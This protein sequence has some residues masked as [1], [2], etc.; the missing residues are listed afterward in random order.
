VL[1]TR[2]E[3]LQ[4]VSD[5]FTDD[6]LAD[7]IDDPTFH[8]V[9]M[10]FIE[11]L[12]QADRARLSDFRTSRPF[13]ARSLVPLVLSLHREPAIRTRSIDLFEHLLDVTPD[14]AEEVLQQTVTT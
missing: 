5:T 13:L 2:P 14:T 8:E 3:I 1:P 11:K 4:N 10:E 7:L 12:I 6:R 9:V